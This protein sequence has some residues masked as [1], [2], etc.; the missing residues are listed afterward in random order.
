MM[1]ITVMDSSSK[2]ILLKSK[3]IYVVPNTRKRG[4]AWKSNLCDGKLQLLK[5]SMSV[6]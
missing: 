3:R 2:N 4:M 6:P 5:V 1:R